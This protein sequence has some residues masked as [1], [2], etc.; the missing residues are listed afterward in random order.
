MQGNLLKCSPI[1]SFPNESLGPRTSIMLI[2]IRQIM[3]LG[4]DVG[5]LDVLMSQMTDAVQYGR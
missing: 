2:C 4:P 1:L 5:E 3:T